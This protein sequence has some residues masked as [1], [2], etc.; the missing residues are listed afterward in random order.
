MAKHEEFKGRAGHRKIGWSHRK[1]LWASVKRE[2]FAV[3][4]T[5]EYENDI[6]VI[7]SFDISEI[8]LTEN[9]IEYGGAIR[10]FHRIPRENNGD[11]TEAT[12]DDGTVRPSE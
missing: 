5:Q 6:V 1:N 2:N 10:E 7:N 9:G 3:L 12:T 11:S 8:S 4:D